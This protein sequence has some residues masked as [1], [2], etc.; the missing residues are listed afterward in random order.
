MKR[1]YSVVLKDGKIIN[2]NANSTD[3]WNKDRTLALCNDG[4]TVGVFNVDNIAG[5]IDSDCIAE[6]E[7]T[8]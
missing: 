5:F 4:N 2:I 3:W 6:R 1:M 8:K 7:E